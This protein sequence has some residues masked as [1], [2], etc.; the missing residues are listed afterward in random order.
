MKPILV[1][2]RLMNIAEYD[3]IRECLDIRWGAFLQQCG[4]LSVI[5][6]VNANIEDYLNFF[7]PQGLI[8]TGGNDVACYQPGDFLNK[9]RD[10]FELSLID[11]IIG[12]KMPILGVCHGMQLIAHYFGLPLQKVE[13]HITDSHPIKI[14]E[15]SIFGKF[16][17]DGETVNSYHRFAVTNNDDTFLTGVRMAKDEIIEGFQH[18]KYNI[19]AIMWHPERNEVFNHKD[20]FFFKDFFA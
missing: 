4:F 7:K 15:Q 13:G 2:Q 10:E 16:Y 6:P 8:L 12:R 3:E 18:R 9:K 14:N 19:A 1:T 17:K 11:M 20:L 5:L